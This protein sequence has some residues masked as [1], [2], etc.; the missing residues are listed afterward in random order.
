MAYDEKLA[1]RVRALLT[2]RKR[3]TEKRMFGGLAFLL[4]GRMCCGVLNDELVVRV[5]PARYNEA[6]VRP[7]ARPMDFTG[8]PLTGFVYVAPAGFRTRPA[9]EK[10]VGLGLEFASTLHAK[11]TK[12]KRGTTRS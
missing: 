7:H 2:A 5:G 11:K 1:E 3:V 6:L 10:W 8:K 4:G 12:N 9:L